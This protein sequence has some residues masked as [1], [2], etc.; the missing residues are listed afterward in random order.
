MPVSFAKGSPETRSETQYS[1]SSD[2]YGLLSLLWFCGVFGFSDSV[3]HWVA[4][5]ARKR[6]VS[7]LGPVSLTSFAVLR[8][9]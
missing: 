4:S 6:A 9:K 2:S 3:L 8:L 7:S 1:S 5:C